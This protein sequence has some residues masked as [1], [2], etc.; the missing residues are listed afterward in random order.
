MIWA[1]YG[2]YDKDSAHDFVKPGK[3]RN[4]RISERTGL[5]PVTYL[6]Q[7]E[8]AT[9][10]VYKPDVLKALS[11][12]PGFFLST[13]LHRFHE[14]GLR[15]FRYN[16]LGDRPRGNILKGQRGKAEHISGKKRS[17]VTAAVSSIRYGEAW[18]VAPLIF[19]GKLTQS[20]MTRLSDTLLLAVALVGM[21]GFRSVALRFFL[22]MVALAQMG[23]SFAFH[24]VDRY[25]MFCSWALL[26][27]LSLFICNFVGAVNRHKI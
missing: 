16:R 5:P 7:S 20:D 13:A 12:R 15:F 22:I 23:F 18:K 6:R 1:A 9:R 24:D 2:K 17:A 19:I 27:G 4:K 26:L 3:L 10:Q 25:F 14:H 11:E 21:F 8:T